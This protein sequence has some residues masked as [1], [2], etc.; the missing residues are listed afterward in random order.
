MRGF[1]PYP[2][3]EH[4]TALSTVNRPQ[5]Q[6]GS[7]Q[8]P[9]QLDDI[10]YITELLSSLQQTISSHTQD[11]NVDDG[12]DAAGFPQPADHY[13]HGELKQILKIQAEFNNGVGDTYQ[14]LKEEFDNRIFAAQRD[15]N[16]PSLWAG[17]PPFIR[18]MSE[19]QDPKE[20]LDAWIKKTLEDLEDTEFKLNNEGVLAV[21]ATLEDYDALLAGTFAETN[22]TLQDLVAKARIDG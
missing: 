1:H 4:P 22:P 18:R 13:R 8:Q 6:F 21:P 11:L 5:I 7:N 20:R 17:F 2:T 10:W 14:S 16:I 19:I 15:R 12:M 3:I 9:C